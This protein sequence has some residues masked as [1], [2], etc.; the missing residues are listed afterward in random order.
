MICYLINCKKERF[1]GDYM[2]F[3]KLIMECNKLISECQEL[4]KEADRERQLF[5]EASERRF[6]K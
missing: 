6:K 2:W 5:I 4:C 1:E 3:I